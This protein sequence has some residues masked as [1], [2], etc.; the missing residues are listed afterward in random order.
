LPSLSAELSTRNPTQVAAAGVS[1]RA[2]MIAYK[3]A[4]QG[5]LGL[6]LYPIVTVQYSST[7][8]YQ[9]SYH[10]QYLFL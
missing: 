1:S 3:R 8:L 7:T 4:V 10:I 5:A 2:S 6:G 9:V